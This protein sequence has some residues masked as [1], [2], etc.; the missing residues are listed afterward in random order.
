MGNYVSVS[1]KCVV[2]NGVR[3][4]LEE[5]MTLE[6]VTI[7]NGSVFINGKEYVGGGKWKT[8]ARALWHKFF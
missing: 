7:I 2:A 3:V 5:G 4:E 8:T 1:N 6:N